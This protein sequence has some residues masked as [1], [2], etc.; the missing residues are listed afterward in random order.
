MTATDQADSSTAPTKSDEVKSPWLNPRR[1]RFWAIVIVM[2]YT[3]LGFLIVP[4]IVKGT[5]T[6]LIEEDLGRTAQ[7]KVV[8]FN[9]YELSLRV[10]QFKMQDTDGVELAAFDELFVNF[11]LSSLFRWAWTF[12][13]IRLDNSYVYFERFDA[14]DS[15]LSRMLAYAATKQ[16]AELEEVEEKKGGGI[17]RL[18][19]QD[20]Q[21]NSGMVNVTDNVPATPVEMNFGPIN[22]AI[23]ELNTLPN[24]YGEQTVN[25][26]L[27][28]NASLRWQGNLSLVPLDSQGEL[29]L[30]N[31]NMGVTTA[32]LKAMLPLEVVDAKLSTRFQYHVQLDNNGVFDL[33]IDNLDVE[34]DDVAVTGLSPSKEF[35]KLK[36]LALMGGIVRYPEQSIQFSSLRFVEPQ[37]DVWRKTDGSLSVNDFVPVSDSEATAEQV[38]EIEAEADSDN[39]QKKPWQ[40]GLNELVLEAGR[41]NF[42]DQSI[43][44]AGQIRITDL[45]IKA[46]DISNQ[47]GAKIPLTVAAKLAEGGGFSLDSTLAILPEF[48]FSGRTKTR[49]IPLALAQ[50]YVQQFSR[51]KVEK[52]KLNSDMAI[53]I[54]AGKPVTVSG[55]LQIPGLEIKDAIESKR[56]LAWKNLAIEHLNLD[57]GANKLELSPLQFE[58]LFGRIII[59]K[60]QSTNL[61]GLVVESDKKPANKDD[62]NGPFDVVIGGVS[63]KQG[64]M[65]FSD[66]SLPLPFATRIKN[67]NGTVSAIATNSA[68]PANIKLEGQVDEF[69]LSRISG[70]INLLD[71]LHRTDITVEFRNLLM[72]SLSPYTIQFAGREIAEGRLN[73]ELKYDIDKSQLQASNKVVVSDLEL[74]AKVDHP[75]AASLPLGLAMAL[76]KDS[77]GIIDLSLPIKGDIDDP[78]FRIGGII[79]QAFSGLIIKA[80]T[81]PFQLLG[82]LI[83][84]ESD[85]FGEFQ[86][87]A[88]RSDLTPP[89]L[90]KVAQLKEA[91]LKRP[92]LNIEI[93]GAV[94]PE[95]DR[96]ALKY[97]ELRSA[98][99]VK[100]GDEAAELESVD[101]LDERLFKPLKILFEERF[102][103]IALKTIRNENKVP[104]A[105]DP[106]GRLSLDKLAYAADLRDRLL[107][108]VKITEEKLTALAQARAETIKAAFLV[109]EFDAGRVEVVETE[110]VESEDG[111][112]VKFELGVTSK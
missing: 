67:L 38:A 74:G 20:L 47:D 1:K 11:Q 87:L 28:D 93:S 12:R 108:T 44:P 14:I 45:L 32:Y 43:K 8:Q 33:D 15:R 64:G 98:L 3:L 23:K 18:L 21:L 46:S 75:D 42:A 82:S 66:L 80:V 69:G 104:P 9:P 99:I 56:L 61:S 110:E 97:S 102:P 10:L 77:N 96:P 54:P 91:L 26:T 57:L 70:A 86:F 94:D 41:F 72:S 109:N 59:Y 62:S 101:I 103:D 25:I 76:L 36:Q 35:F 27:P 105:D 31:S 71:P 49:G 89:E 73:L 79:W 106:E 92:K 65:E 2:L 50:P 39:E 34:L 22:I 16:P 111:Q 88:G 17:P 107:E 85:D 19:I 78:E 100:L 7:I 58:Q 30:K 90:E 84:V 51:I 53:N 6:R 63:V 81:A 37:L 4:V 5:V 68:E 13:E 52:G 55:A 112:W 95:I 29:E 40:V 60:D 83:G 24:R 48:S